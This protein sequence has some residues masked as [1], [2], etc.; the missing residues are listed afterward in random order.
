MLFKNTGDKIIYMYISIQERYKMIE[1]SVNEF[2]ISLSI[3]LDT[4]RTSK[5]VGLILCSM[6]VYNYVIETC[7]IALQ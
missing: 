7:L 2:S 1:E 4:N 3:G 6:Y 5:K